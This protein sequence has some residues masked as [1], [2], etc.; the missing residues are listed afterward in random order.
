MPS[1]P[2]YHPDEKFRTEQG[3]VSMVPLQLYVL[4]DDDEWKRKDVTNP[5]KPFTYSH[6]A[7][8]G[9][10]LPPLALFTKLDDPD[11]FP[12]GAI[13]IQVPG[14]VAGRI[15]VRDRLTWK[16][17]LTYLGVSLAVIGLTLA[18]IASGHHL[19]RRAR[20]LGP[21]RLALAGATAAG[22]DLAEHIQ[23]DN[24]DARTA[25][26]D[27]AQIL[28]GVANAGALAA[29]RIV[30]AAGAPRPPRGGAAPGRTR[31]CCPSGRTSPS[32]SVRESPTASPSRSWPRARCG[33]STRS[34]RA[35][36]A[37]ARRAGRRCCC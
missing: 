7:K 1:T 33:S 21:R 35:L 17:F 24:L 30:V 27:L 36:P 10:T 25:V 12:A 9:E 15:G 4:K 18:T 13:N 5:A 37:P 23:H 31:Q 14:G 2:S 3:F 16:K 32:C 19:G 6:D 28:A 20:R 34:R 8:P 29:G 26:L 22:S 11:H